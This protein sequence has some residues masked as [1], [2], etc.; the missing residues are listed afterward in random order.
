MK[1]TNKYGLPEPLVRALAGDDY[2]LLDAPEN[3]ISVTTLIAP[4]K[5]KILEMRHDAEIEID[6]SER[7]WMVLGTAC[8]YVVD[9][10]AGDDHLNEERW[11]IEVSTMKVF[12]APVGKKAQNCDWYK[13]T[14][15]Y[16]SG[17]FDLYDNKT[18]RL[19]DYK[20][21]SVWS[22]LIEKKMKPEHEAQLNINAL[23]I[24]MIG[25]WVEKISIM[26]MFRDWSKTKAKN[27]YPNLPVPMKEI[28]GHL[29]TDTGI[30]MYI[31]ARV[32]LHYQQRKV[33]D[34]DI[35]ECLPEERWMKPTTY[36]MMK[37]SNKRATK[38]FYSKPNDEQ[39]AQFLGMSVVERP[40]VDT[41]CVDY[42]NAAPFC[43]YWQS[44]Y[45][46]M[47]PITE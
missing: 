17:K 30:T 20:I 26:M 7:L 15:I 9:K 31:K 8:H 16:V 14:E 28:E 39:L 4:P 41:K 24:R 10:A 46:N 18:H 2:D 1:F 35:P 27:D 44:K 5:Q 43:H 22:W 12:T 34:D 38:V 25:F 13:I 40:G 29:W 23:A 36:A 47:E 37:G 19:S 45:K 33:A 11:Y 21:T 42:C 3:I 6:I 32:D